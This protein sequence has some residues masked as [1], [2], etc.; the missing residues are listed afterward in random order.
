MI[1]QENIQE[2]FTIDL[3]NIFS[4][5]DRQK[6]SINDEDFITLKTSVKKF[7]GNYFGTLHKLYFSLITKQTYVKDL[8]YNI[9]IN[10]ENQPQEYGFEKLS[11]MIRFIV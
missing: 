3:K 7:F 2:E 4:K 5:I 10:L 6:C 11:D 8:Y 1:N 9:L